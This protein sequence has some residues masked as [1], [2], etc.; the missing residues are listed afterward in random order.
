MASNSYFFESSVRIS[1]SGST[2]RLTLPGVINYFQDC[3]TLQSESMNLGVKYFQEHQRAWVLSYWQIEIAR[4]P[5]LGEKVTAETW[6]TAFKGMF[7]ERNF[8]LWD[9]NEKVAARAHSLWVYMD[10]AKGRPVK[11]TPEEIEP[12]GEGQ[13]LD[14][15]PTSRKITRPEQT[16]ERECFKVR[17]YQIDTNRHMNNC[18]YVQLAMELV[19]EEFLPHKIRVEYKKSAVYNDI[20]YPKIAVEEER[21]V[22]ELC[23]EAGGLYAIVELKK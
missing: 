10:M 9:G 1:E 7:G 3:S 4:Y 23:D 22:V 8:Q 5:E 13:A 17:R 16:E 6:A 12:Y 20:I 18:Q 14:M 15:E 2:G 11:P 19:G 21:T